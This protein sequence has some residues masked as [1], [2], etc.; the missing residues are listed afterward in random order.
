M[1]ETLEKR[2]EEGI[3]EIVDSIVSDCEWLRG[4]HARCRRGRASYSGDI[5]EWLYC[6]MAQ[7]KGGVKAWIRK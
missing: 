5:R 7:S 3:R 6:W 4:L 1:S 2:V